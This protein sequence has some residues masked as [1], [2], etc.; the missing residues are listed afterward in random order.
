M[1]P[2]PYAIS[3]RMSVRHQTILSMATSCP[4]VAG[5]Q[6][7]PVQCL[8]RVLRRRAWKRT[9][10]VSHPSTVYHGGGPPGPPGGGGPPATGS[11]RP[12]RPFRSLRH[13]PT[14]PGVGTWGWRFGGS[15]PPNDACAVASLP[16]QSVAAT[17]KL[18]TPLSSEPRRR[19]GCRCIRAALVMVGGFNLLPV[20][21]SGA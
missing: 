16:S 3:T 11:A 14:G 12:S 17:T 4:R 18:C 9:R 20:Q 5:Y 19:V 7:V 13:L 8:R 1:K 10:T 21:L 6:P 15:C 2:A